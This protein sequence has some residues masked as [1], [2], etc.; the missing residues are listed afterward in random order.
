MVKS[1]IGRVEL[2]QENVSSTLTNEIKDT[3]IRLSHFIHTNYGQ[4]LELAELAN[5]EDKKQ[6]YNY[7]EKLNENFSYMVA[8]AED[9]ISVGFY[10]KDGKQIYLKQNIKFSRDSVEQTNW[11]KEAKEHEGVVQIGFFAENV[12][13]TSSKKNQLALVTAI[14]PN[15]VMD[16]RY[17]ME[18]VALLVY[19]DIGEMMDNYNREENLGTMCLVDKRGN[20]ILNAGEELT[21]PKMGLFDQDG[22]YE[23]QES[24]EKML[25]KI[26]EVE[27]SDWYL[28]S[29]VRNSQLVKGFD[30][31]A[32]MIMF[33]TI[34]LF[35]LF[36]YYSYITLRNSRLEDE[37]KHQAEIKALQSQ[38]NPHFL[39]N[40]LTSIR[41]MAQVSK[42]DGIK[43]MAEA[44]INILTHSFRSNTRFY[45]VGEE[46]DVLK[47]YE[48][49][50]KIRY[51]DGFEIYY[52]VEEECLGYQVPRLILQPIIENSIVHGFSDSEDIG[53]IKVQVWSKDNKLHFEIVDNG[54]GMS[55]KEID[56]VLNREIT[57]DNT[58]IGVFNVNTRL[59]LYF[60]KGNGIKMESVLGEYTKTIIELPLIK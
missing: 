33:T 32:K 24:G 45:S 38:I 26:S 22:F 15:R 55:Q 40:T 16:K 10:F 9:I 23:S 53:K 11:Y 3:K 51:S 31:I 20:I 50:M 37:K 58:N 1:A 39:V 54:K 35:V 8:P 14:A 36:T 4:V 56:M 47:S 2:A 6:A 27:S 43:N 30:S 17:E 21:I 42:F 12:T 60:G 59:K 57:K 44:L 49:L 48:F 5:S 52:E 46:L 41:F 13:Y 18:I 25:F 19:S 34:L 28:V 29:R 7:M